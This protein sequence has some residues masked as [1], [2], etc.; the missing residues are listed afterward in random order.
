MQKYTEVVTTK[1]TKVQKNTLEKL[2]NNKVNVSRF[3]RE[4]IREK[5]QREGH[6]ITRKKTYCP[7]SG[8]T[9]EI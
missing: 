3:V 8:G 5:I 4:A 6:E 2:R 7:F 1:I 9:I